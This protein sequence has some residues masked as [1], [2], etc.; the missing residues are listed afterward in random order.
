MNS[1]V[2]GVAKSWTWL[3]NFHFTIL[4]KREFKKPCLL[5]WIF[6]NRKLKYDFLKYL[7]V[8][9]FIWLCQVLIVASRIFSSRTWTLSCG[10]QDLVPRP[11]IELRPRALGAHKLSHWTTREILTFFV[12]LFVCLFLLLTLKAFDLKSN[13]EVFEEPSFH[14]PWKRQKKVFYGLICKYTAR[15][16]RKRVLSFRKSYL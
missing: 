14:R 7:L 16:T 11:G 9:L 3:S 12:C 15:H 10:M 4:L 5:S 8:N 1:I 2:H 6:S 13:P